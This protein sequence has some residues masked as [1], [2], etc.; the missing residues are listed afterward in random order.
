MDGMG[1]VDGDGIGEQDCVETACLRPSIATM[2]T[3]HHGSMERSSVR[4]EQ[5]RVLSR[6]AQYHG[7]LSGE[8][9]GVIVPFF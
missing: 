4:G 7:R 3:T 1:W 5:M 8:E 6:T 9:D 2:T